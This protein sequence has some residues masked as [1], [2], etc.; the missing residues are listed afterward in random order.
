[1]ARISLAPREPVGD[2]EAMLNAIEQ[3][4]GYLPNN[5]LIMAHWPELLSAFSGLGGTI[6]HTG[7]IEAELKQLMAMV[8]STAHGCEYCQAHTSHAAHQHGASRDKVAAVF[9]FESST[10]FTD[11]ERAAL[12]L[13]WH[14]ALQPNQ[15]SDSDFEALRRHFNDREI[16]ELVAVI[17]LF[18]FLNRWSDTMGSEL[19]AL[20]K[21]FADTLELSAHHMLK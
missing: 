14:G 11:R 5:L 7:V 15:V 20:P 10:L 1:M 3:T 17:S 21:E 12:R 4:M 2:Q 16:V 9:E 13:A 6:L 18:G 8:A 19:E